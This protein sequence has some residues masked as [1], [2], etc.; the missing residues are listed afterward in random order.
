[1]HTFLSEAGALSKHT[2]PC[3]GPLLS[4]AEELGDFDGLRAAVVFKDLGEEFL[5][6]APHTGETDEKKMMAVYAATWVTAQGAQGLGDNHG[7]QL[8]AGERL[9]GWALDPMQRVA[10]E[11][12]LELR[13]SV[14]LSP[15]FWQQAVDRSLLA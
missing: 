12:A 9:K 6:S 4:S 5:S 13:F 15:A 11:K 8:F 2:Q 7:A 1:M 10:I 3:G 14:L